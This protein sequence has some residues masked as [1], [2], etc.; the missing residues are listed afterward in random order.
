MKMD[1][2]RDFVETSGR[3]SCCAAP[4]GYLCEH[5][6][7]LISLFMRLAAKE[8]VTLRIINKK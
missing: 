3:M 8:G 7:M 6:V 4:P 2:K 1:D 5:M